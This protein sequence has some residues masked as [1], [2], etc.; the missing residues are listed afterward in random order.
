MP[1]THFEFRQSFRLALADA[2]I[3]KCLN[4]A[5][6][7][8]FASY[9]LGVLQ[10]RCLGRVTTRHRDSRMI[11]EHYHEL[12]KP[13]DAERYWDIRPAQWP[14]WYTCQRAAPRDGIAKLAK[15]EQVV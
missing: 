10:R 9:P 13:K 3:S 5:L 6:R 15:S 12:V 14:S 8:S 2:G 4:S 1:K 11:F 7:H